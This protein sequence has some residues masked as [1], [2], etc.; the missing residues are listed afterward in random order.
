MFRLLPKTKKSEV[1]TYDI[2]LDHPPL[3]TTEG[4]AV[5]LVSNFKNLGSWVNSTEQDIKVRN[6][7]R[8]SWSVFGPSYSTLTAAHA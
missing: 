2:L 8:E 4:N 3:R 5:K 7:N 6:M 1:I